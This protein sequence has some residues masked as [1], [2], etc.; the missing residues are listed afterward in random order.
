[1]KKLIASALLATTLPFTGN[2]LAADYTLDTKG[3]HTAIEFAV[4]HLGFGWVNGR[5]NEFEGSFSFDEAKPEDSTL[6]VT[7]KTTT[8]DSNHAERDKHLRGADYLNTDKFGEAT[9]K[10]TSF[11]L[12]ED[13]KGTLVGD[14]TLNGVTKPLT[15]DVKMTNAGKDPW[16]GERIGFKGDASFALKDYNITK[17]GDAEVELDLF[18]EGIKNK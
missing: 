13:K 7:I 2:A 10:S 3:A 12:G 17:L 4:S 1:M 8:V 11:K 15:I 5:F 6:N 16:G 9:F 18:V 14:F